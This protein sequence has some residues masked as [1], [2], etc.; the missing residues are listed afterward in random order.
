V[1]PGSLHPDEVAV[2]PRQV[3]RLLSSQ[4]PQWATLP[5]TP[6]PPSGTDHTL[7]RLGE[8]LLVRM[9]R[10]G[11]AVTQVET[12]RQWLTR[13][14]PF[15]PVP[16]P[17]PVAVG[18]PGDS[19]P[20]RWSIV[21]WLPGRNPE[22]TG[23]EALARDVA[24]FIEALHNADAGGGP[25]KTGDQ[26]GGPLAGRDEITR[27]AIAQL[28]DRIDGPA[29]LAAWAEAVSAP[30]APG[31]AGWVHGDLEPG[32]LL[33][34]GDRL[35]GVIDFAGL[36]LGDQAVDLLP[37]WSLFDERGRQA[38]RSA[39]GADDDLWARGRGWAL[40]TALLALPYYWDT[41]P[42]MVRR[43]QDKIAAVLNSPR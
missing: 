28:G 27:A 22:L 37:A 14:A 43:S 10:I 13:L 25:V 32:N 15:L 31:P 2:T 18:E 16:V 23:S 4:F 9:P 36:G 3:R 8:D 41:F 20:W 29:V 19:Y 7:Y 33:V 40:T 34:I 6:I 11:W 12:D 21:P 5:L 30:A 39:V 24:E 35:T 1:V 17:A 42:A 38:F 26:R